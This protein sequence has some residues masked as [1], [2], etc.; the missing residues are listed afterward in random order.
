MFVRVT[1]TITTM[2]DID[3]MKSEHT[4][5][6]E[7]EDGVPP[8]MS[9]MAAAVGCRATIMGLPERIRSMVLPITEED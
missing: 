1:T 7:A 2:I 8:E 9:Y 3:N 4:S 5:E 6:I